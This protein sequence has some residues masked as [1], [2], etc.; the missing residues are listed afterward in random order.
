MKHLAVTSHITVNNDGETV[1]LRSELEKLYKDGHVMRLF[2]QPVSDYYSHTNIFVNGNIDYCTD[3]PL[4]VCRHLR[5][6]RRE[7]ILTFTSVIFDYAKNEIRLYTDHGRIMRPLYI[8]GPDNE[9]VMNTKIMDKI[10]SGEMGWN[11]LL[12]EQI[13]EYV[14]IHELQY[15]CLIAM[16][17]SWVRK[18][19][20]NEEFFVQFT[21]CEIHPTAILGISA[22]LIPFPNFEHSPRVT[23]QSVMVKQSMDPYALNMFLR[24]DTVVNWL[25]TPQKPLTTTYASQLIYSDIMPNGINTIVMFACFTGF[26]QDDSL[27]FNQSSADRGMF[28]SY[29]YKTYVEELQP[30]RTYVNMKPDP[31]KTLNYKIRSSYDHINADGLPRVGATVHHNDVILG[32][33]QILPDS[34]NSEIKYKDKSVLYKDHVPGVISKVMVAPNMSNEKYVRIVVQMYMKPDIGDKLSARH[35]QKGTCGLIDRQDEFPYLPGGIIPDLIVNPH[36]IPSR[37]T[38]GMLKEMLYNMLGLA[39]GN[40]FECSAF[41]NY[42]NEW[43]A[44]QLKLAGLHEYCNVPAYHPTTGE[45][46]PV[47]IFTAPAYYQ[48]LKHLVGAKIQ[49]RASGPKTISM[50]QPVQGKKEGGGSRFGEMERDALLGHGVSDIIQEKFLIESD[51][52]HLYICDTCGLP[53]VGNKKTNTFRCDRCPE[54][55]AIYKIY[56]PYATKKFFQET[57]SYGIS[58]RFKL[59]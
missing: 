44:E 38:I 43:I 4:H 59:E 11:D 13:I 9:L 49:A 45:L 52:F 12:R 25:V 15:N 18:A 35:G 34:Q 5:M 2:D 27:K 40:Y 30:N 53:A 19:K 16:W 32:R 21:H 54:R 50:R 57:T 29:H 33:V 26:N 31:S 58:T 14:C 24:F 6:R 7:G 36:A 3:N 28:N 42:S 41:G 39:T 56:I 1:N 48:R 23:F 17:P 10:K 37:M 46:M 47:K 20:N 55:T 51:K 8:V 22:L